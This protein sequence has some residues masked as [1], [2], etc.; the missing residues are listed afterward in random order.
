M[1]EY[2]LEEERG[3]RFIL[4]GA[5]NITCTLNDVTA[6]IEPFDLKRSILMKQLAINAC[7]H[8][9]LDLS[10]GIHTTLSRSP[11]YLGYLPDGA[12]LVGL[13]SIGPRHPSQ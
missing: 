2:A 7:Q 6:Q 8:Y 10:E 4:K 13:T 9:S 12:A 3:K 11:R 5:A 1:E